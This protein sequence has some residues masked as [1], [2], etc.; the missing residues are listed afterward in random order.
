MKFKQLG[1][2]CVLVYAL[3][4]LLIL[5]TAKPCPE[6]AASQTEEVEEP[7]QMDQYR[8]ILEKQRNQKHYRD[9]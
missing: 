8:T 2:L 1:A 4:A 9:H 3:I 6:K 5:V 7:T